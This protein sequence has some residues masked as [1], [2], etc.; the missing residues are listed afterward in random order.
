M[1]IVVFGI[2]VNTSNF[3][4]IFPKKKLNKTIKS[5]KKV[6][7][8]ISVSFMDIQLLIEFLFF[9]YKIVRLG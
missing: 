5:T 3:S 1:I 7:K 2:E 9:Y 8:E 6:L 4:A